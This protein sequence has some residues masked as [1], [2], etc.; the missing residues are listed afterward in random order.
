MSAGGKAAIAVVLVVAIVAAIIGVLWR[1]KRQQSNVSLHKPGEQARTANEEEGEGSN[2]WDAIT[3]ET[4]H[5]AGFNPSAMVGGAG[6]EAATSNDYSGGFK[7]EANVTK[8]REIAREHLRKIGTV[9]KGQFGEVRSLSL[10]LSL[11]LS[12]STSL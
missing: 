10:S 5:N 12:F 8:I 9:G 11:S 1:C 3:V 4:V 6:K 2:A 7:T